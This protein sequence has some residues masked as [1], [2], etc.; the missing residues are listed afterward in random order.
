[1]EKW[2]EELLKSIESIASEAGVRPDGKDSGTM[3]GLKPEELHSNDIVF[4]STSRAVVVCR[5]LFNAR[6]IPV[7]F[8]LESV[9]PAFCRIFGIAPE[10]AA[11]RSGKEFFMPDGKEIPALDLFDNAL[12]E[13]QA[14]SFMFSSEKSPPAAGNFSSS[15]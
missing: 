7:D 14:F 2:N 9:N 1:M 4:R 12:K 13:Q 15:E 3:E 5:M 10:S 8:L 11:G 6:G